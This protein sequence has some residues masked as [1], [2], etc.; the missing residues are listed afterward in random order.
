M[1]TFPN[2]FLDGKAGM[3]WLGDVHGSREVDYVIDDALANNLAIGFIGDL[4]D[5]SPKDT[6]GNANDSAHVLRRVIGLIRDGHATMVPGNHCA[7]LFRYF[8]K[9]VQGRGEESTIKVS[10]GLDQTIEEI[11]TSEDRDFLITGLLEIIGNAP[12]W[13]RSNRYVFVHAGATGGMFYETPPLFKDAIR[14]KSGL[15]HRALYGETNG[16]KSSDGF[17]VR[18]YDWVNRLQAGE[19]AVIGHDIRKQITHVEGNQGGKLIHIDTGAGKG[20]HL[21]Y[22]DLMIEELSKP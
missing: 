11:M 15:F 2:G 19:V 10:H 7:K 4:T 6:T 12:L 1:N 13:H 9:F 21:S 3:R 16:E 5:Q 18:L 17:P 8:T 14:K 22:L 20:G